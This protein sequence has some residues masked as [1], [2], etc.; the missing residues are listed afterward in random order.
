[1]DSSTGPAP[2][3]ATPSSE[4]TR[5]VRSNA[6]YQS[7]DS[8]WTVSD[9]SLNRL[10]FAELAADIGSGTSHRGETLGHRD[11]AAVD[12]AGT[13]RYLAVRGGRAGQVTRAAAHFAPD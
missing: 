2:V 7:G 8:R 12:A 6:R 5:S 3:G 1:M 13:R 9:P 4:A 11:G 10:P